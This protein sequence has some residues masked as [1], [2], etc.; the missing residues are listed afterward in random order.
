MTIDSS[1]RVR[2]G[3]QGNRNVLTRAERLEKL[4]ET[5][6]WHEGDSVFGLPKVRVQRIILKKKKKLKKEEEETDEAVVEIVEEEME[7]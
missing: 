7:T 6:R 3:S 5:E 1:L 2:R 4:Q